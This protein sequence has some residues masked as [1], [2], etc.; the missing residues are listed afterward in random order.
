MFLCTDFHPNTR[1][2]SLWFSSHSVLQSHLLYLI[3]KLWAAESNNNLGLNKR[4]ILLKSEKPP[5]LGHTQGTKILQGSLAIFTNSRFGK[6]LN[7]S[8]NVNEKSWLHDW[9]RRR[10]WETDAGLSWG[11]GTGSDLKS[12]WRCCSDPSL[13]YD[14]YVLLSHCPTS[15]GF[16]E[17]GGTVGRILKVIPVIAIATT[18]LVK[19]LTRV[20]PVER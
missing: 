11:G 14:K 20:L 19:S 6:D 12:W 1:V 3:D 17:L 8:D 2:A 18:R 5:S 10:Q 4:T 15:P 13:L 9:N 16:R 7:F